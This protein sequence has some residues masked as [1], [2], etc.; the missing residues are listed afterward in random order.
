MVQ[1][2]LEFIEESPDQS[3]RAVS[4]R[5]LH[6][7]RE[8][9]GAEAGSVFMLHR[10]G[11]AREL[12]AVSVQN[13]V[14]RAPGR[15]FSLPADLFSIAGYVALTGDTVF[16]EDAYAIPKDRPYR[17]NPS[18]D[19]HTGFRTRS[20]LTFAL[21]GV[22]GRSIGVVQ[23]INRRLPGCPDPLPFLREHEEMIAPVNHLVGRALERAATTERL[24]ERNRALAKERRRVAELQEETERAFMV[25]VHLL[26]KAAELHDED[27][28]NHILR[29]N[30]YSY[31]LARWAGCPEEFCAEIRFSA[32]LHD[33]GKMSVDQAILRKKGR[34]D[35]REMAEMKR[36]P[37]YGHE[38]LIA[39]DRLK[40]AAD[41]AL[42][43]HEQ[44]AG[45]GYPNGLAGEAIPLSARIVAVADCYD[46]LR[47]KRPY[48]PAFPHERTM[49]IL[50][51][52]DDRITPERHF[53]PRLLSLLVQNQDEFA[54]IWESLRDG[55]SGDD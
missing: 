5:V 46:A 41:I 10:R 40:M 52:G 48:K 1:Q 13:D 24:R 18:F 30:E 2:F 4:Q 14:V 12:T 53:D 49:A 38:I 36:H 21:K 50:T 25:S 27:T 47:S 32:A 6:K 35:E 15:A 11:R 45:T 31:A 33:V 26:A 19:R 16:I 17:F 42:C 7:C 54:R 51:Q 39:S 22:G 20:I 55:C 23:L 44:W 9:T 8:L 37:V 28:G 3:V 29:V 43:H 34:L